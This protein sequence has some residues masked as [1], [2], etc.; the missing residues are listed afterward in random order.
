MTTPQP[1]IDSN[2]PESRLQAMGLVLPTPPKP[3]AAY[4]PFRVS[5]NHVF[6]A[7][8][9][10]F[11][12]GKLLAAGAVPAKVPVPL[13]IECARQC[14]LNGLAVVREAIAAAGMDGG[15]SRVV[16]FVRLGVFVACGP[17]F[18]DHPK[19]ANG[20]SELLVEVFGDRGRHARAAVGAPSLPLGA[21][22][23]VEF[24]VEVG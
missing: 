13:A 11:R 16:Q 14:A 2:S 9:I 19:V 21:P 5:G 12:D 8:Q 7:G 20:A 23:E 1:N 6:V 3:V 10:P 24:V 15:L 22:V 4:I 17:E 18:T